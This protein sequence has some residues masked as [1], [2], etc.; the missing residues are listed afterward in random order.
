MLQPKKKSFGYYIYLGY[1]FSS[2]KD[3]SINQV[4]LMMNLSQIDDSI[5]II[6]DLLDKSKK[7]NGKKCLYLKIGIKEAKIE[8]KKIEKKAKDNLKILIKEFDLKKKEKVLEIFEK[9]LSEIKEGQKIDQINSHFHK[10]DKMLEKRYFKMIKLFTGGQIKRGLEIGQIFGNGRINRTL[11]KNA[12]RIGMIR[13][14][15]DDFEDYFNLHHE[16][17]GDLKNNSNRFP[18]IVF[19]KEGGNKKEIFDLLKQEKYALIKEKILNKKVRK[20]IF[21]YCKS[22]YKK[23]DKNLIELSRLEIPNF[24]KIIQ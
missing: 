13:Q 6:D 1:L 12:E 8:A 19:M 22:I 7:R 24:Q 17:L 9:F 23:L 14:I 21:L 5:L 16:P 2:K 3:P 20:D 15:L 18:E 10:Y 11:S 4:K